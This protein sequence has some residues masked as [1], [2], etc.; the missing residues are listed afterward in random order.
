M[1]TDDHCER[2]KLALIS[3]SDAKSVIIP[4][5]P[6]F[7]L[8]QTSS[9]AITSLTQPYAHRSS[10]LTSFN[11]LNVEIS[12]SSL[13]IDNPEENPDNL[14]IDWSNSLFKPAAGFGQSKRR[15]CKSSSDEI[16][17]SEILPNQTIKTSKIVSNTDTLKQTGRC[18]AEFMPPVLE[19]R[20]LSGQFG[21]NPTKSKIFQLVGVSKAVTD[22]KHLKTAFGRDS[23]KSNLKRLSGGL[24]RLTSDRKYQTETIN[25]NKKIFHLVSNNEY[26]KLKDLLETN[27][28][29][30]NS[31]D[32]KQRT[33]LHIASARGNLDIVRLLLDYGANPNIRDC[34]SNLPIH[35][36]IISSHVPVVTLLLEAGTD[37]HSLDENGN[38]VLHLAG[39]RLRWLL[40]DDNIQVSAKLKL[41]AIM[42][43]DMIKQYLRKKKANT[44]D[45]DMLADRLESV[46]NL[47]DV[48]RSSLDDILNQFDTLNIQTNSQQNMTN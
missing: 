39:T 31:C 48:N 45:L 30:V 10:I 35:L 42:I 13:E 19:T 37:I 22:L 27:I 16:F 43:M 2:N 14:G 40:N 3:L 21:F 7:Q 18:S 15:E 8:K 44:A 12:S 4:T 46:I 38:T 17:I 36:A 24:A 26:V 41:E 1:E 23:K 25:H 6:I 5:I 9:Q 20:R 29:D 11:N 33:C 34:V 28:H 32:D 47:E